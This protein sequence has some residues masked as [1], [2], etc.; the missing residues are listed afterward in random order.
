MAYS[1]EEEQEINQLKDWWKENGKTIIVAFILGVGGMFGWRYWQAHQ[2]EKI[3]QASAQ[4]DALIYSAQQDEQA[5]KANI[6]QFVQANSKTAYAVFAL[7]DEAKKATEK[8]DF[9]AAEVNLNQALTQSQDE[10][11]TSIVALRLSAVQFQLGQLDNA[12]TTLNQ[13]KG[14]SFNARKAILTGDIQVAKGDKVAAKNS[15]EQAQQS[16]SQL[17]QQMA[18]MKLNNL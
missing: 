18:K 3:A 12:L 5:K 8:Q 10:V 13:V 14:E 11:L 17:E 16:G 2:A 7:L 1:I 15:F 9:A 6:E 4:Y